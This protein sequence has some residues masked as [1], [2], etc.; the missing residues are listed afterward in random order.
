MKKSVKVARVNH[1]NGFFFGN[2]TLVDKVAGNFKRGVSG[3]LSVTGLE[4]KE[5]AVLNGELHILHI[6]IVV[7]KNTAYIFEL[8]KSFRE[9]FCHLADGH[10]STNAGNNVFALCVGKEFA[11]KVFFTGG[12]VTGK[13]NAGSAVIAHI[14]E[15]HGLYVNGGTPGIRNIIVAAIYVG[16][17]VIPASEYCFDGA[18]KLF[19]GVGG[20]I[21][22]DFVFIF[23]L[24]LLRKLFKV[25]GGQL[26]V[27][28][29]VAFGFHFVN[30]LF[31]IFFTDLHNNI[32]IHLD[33]TAV[34]VPGPTGVI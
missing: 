1:G 15:Y 7:F 32:G 21:N 13:G 31:E 16:S 24:E 23:S 19:F 30:K 25:V 9:F 28:L 14:A 8:L 10:R 29:D 33:E 2:H 3:T 5:L 34:A 18:D 17:G 6:A 12:G 22:A 11:H 27:K 4:H 20:E 26:N